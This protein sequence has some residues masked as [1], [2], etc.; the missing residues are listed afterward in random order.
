MVARTRFDLSAGAVQTVVFLDQIPWKEF[1][2]S[3]H[4]IWRI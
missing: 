1:A 2:N 3:I 4:G